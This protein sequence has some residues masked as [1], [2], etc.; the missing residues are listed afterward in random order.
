MVNTVKKFIFLLLLV[1]P[2]ICFADER[3]DLE[4]ELKYQ[5]EHLAKLQEEFEKVKLDAQITQA[6]I[7]DID[8]KLKET[9]KKE[10]ENK[11]GEKNKD[12]N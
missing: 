10:M 4:A 5:K 11:K 9:D 7:I 6:R 1:I 12:I 8:K 2:L 3:K